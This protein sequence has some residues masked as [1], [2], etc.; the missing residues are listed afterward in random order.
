MSRVQTQ[1]LSFLAVTLVGRNRIVS[2]MLDGF[3]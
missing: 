3:G 2:P 1:M